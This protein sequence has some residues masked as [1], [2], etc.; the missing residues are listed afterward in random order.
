VSTTANVIAWIPAASLATA[1]AA[2]NPLL[3]SPNAPGTNTFSVKLSPT[4][5]APATAYGCCAPVNTAVSPELMAALPSLKAS[6]GGDYHVVSWDT[7]SL[8]TDCL[9]WWAA[10][11]L[12]PILGPS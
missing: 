3:A 1:E 8:Q 7:Y 4:G 12:V 2:V 9:N 11:G 5:S 6:L 10:A